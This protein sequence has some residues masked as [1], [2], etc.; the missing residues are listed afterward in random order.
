MCSAPSADRY[1]VLYSTKSMPGT[2]NRGH[3]R[4]TIITYVG[5]KRQK[6]HESRITGKDG[7]PGESAHRYV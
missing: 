3:I 4:Y 5:R 7:F 1:T 6:E 2:R